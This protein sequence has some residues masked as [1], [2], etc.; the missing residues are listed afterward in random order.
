MSAPE[1]IE[2]G[3]FMSGF[4]QAL[5]G[6]TADISSS[7]CHDYAH[8]SSSGILKL[9][10]SK[11]SAFSAPPGEGSAHAKL[12]EMAPTCQISRRGT[13]RTSYMLAPQKA[14]SLADQ[15]PSSRG[16]NLG[17]TG[18]PVAWHRAD[19]LG[20][21]CQQRSDGSRRQRAHEQICRGLSWQALLRR[22]RVCRHCREPCHRARESSSSAPSTSTCSRTAARTPTWPPIWR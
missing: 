15:D 7:A 11:S 5:D 21:L 1:T 13:W 17:R 10:Q 2:H 6:K 22:L 20:K 9:K 8:T 16:G 18:P 12:A 19:C 3:D 4:N 14:K